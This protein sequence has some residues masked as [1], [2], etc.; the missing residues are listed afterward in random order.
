M[1]PLRAQ[2]TLVKSTPELWAEVS[3][4]ESLSRHLGELAEGEIRITRAQPEAEVA[5]EGERARGTV[6]LE[7]AGWGTKVTLTAEV[8]GAEA[9]APPAPEPEPE[10]EPEEPLTLA[11]AV[12]DL[13]GGLEPTEADPEP[14]A[15]AESEPRR[16]FLTRFRHYW[17]SS[18]PE[19][20]APEPEPVP[21]PEPEPVAAQ[22]EPEPPPPAPEPEPAPDDRTLELLTEVLENLGSAHHRPFS[23]G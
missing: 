6:A 4:P 12:S 19:P 14:P 11:G 23:R 7:A 8:E 1:A 13:L 20:P 22:P 18:Q 10:P 2:R 3:D 16:G 17:R 21:E 15:V 9:P 5:W